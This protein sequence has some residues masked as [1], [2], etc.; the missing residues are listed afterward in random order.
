MDGL[1]GQ[2]IASEAG[3]LASEVV[4]VGFD[5]FVRF[6]WGGY[7]PVGALLE[8]VADKILERS[9]GTKWQLKRLHTVAIGPH[10]VPLTRR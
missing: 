8:G 5:G 6:P 7:R 1:F 2:F 9:E 3:W 10:H 4:R